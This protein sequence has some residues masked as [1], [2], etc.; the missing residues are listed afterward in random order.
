MGHKKDE[1]EKLDSRSYSGKHTHTHR[2]LSNL[3]AIGLRTLEDREDEAFG[4]GLLT[5]T[6]LNKHLDSIC[7]TREGNR[8]YCRNS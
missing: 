2:F 7:N 5:L 3:T 6:R 4:G 8:S 1:D